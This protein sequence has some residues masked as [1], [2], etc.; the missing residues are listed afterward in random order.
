MKFKSKTMTFAQNSV[1]TTK[2]G[3]DLITNPLLNKG[4]A[5]T[6]EERDAYF[7]H[8]LL[9]CHFAT[10]AEQ[11]QRSYET[12]CRKDSDI[13]KYIYLRDLQDS[14][15]TLFYNLICT[16]MTEML[17]IVYTPVVGQGCQSFSETYRRPRG[18]YLAYPNQDRIEKILSAPHFQNTKIIVVSDGERILGLGDQGAG[19][20]GIP[21]GKLA[22]YSACAGVHPATT[23]PILLDTGTNNQER[24]NDPLYIGWKHERIRG[25][26]YDT[27][28]ETFVRAIKHQF[29]HVVLQW[30]DFAQQNAH[31]ILDKYREQLC[32]FNDDIQG[33]AAVATA[34]ILSALHLSGQ[35]LAEQ[36]IVVLGGGSAGCGINDLLIAAMMTEG[37]SEAEALSR[38]YVI[39]R[40][41]LL[42][43]GMKDLL[44]FQTKFCQAKEK[45]QDWPV[46]QKIELLDVIKQVH[47]TILIGV[48]GQ[49]GAFTETIVRT[50]AMHTERPIILPLSNPTICS[51]AQPSDLLTWTNGRAIIGTGSPFPPVLLNGISTR[52]DQTNNAYI[53]PGLGL[54]LIAVQAN[55]VTD[56]LFM[57]AAKALADC[58]PAIKDPQG[59]LLPPLERIREVSYYI[60]VAV[61]KEAVKTGLTQRIPEETIDSI[62]GQHMWEPVYASYT[63]EQDK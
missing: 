46:K 45:I 39:D 10:I 3:Y 48:S 55:K 56:H 26:E 44:P 58:S 21:I 36:R 16:Y 40:Q 37:V 62:V 1:E 17:P 2:S 32:T 6:P 60:A 18:L 47:P 4:M 19:G 27:F 57:T 15:E 24:I 34:T 29:P 25:K 9:P 51:E 11:R 54:G 30:E 49:A 13:E 7:L 35:T 59:N 53:F 41:G 33:T 20:M 31:P 50:M 52:I 43:T 14:N 22:L 63:V 42:I 23:L 12:F 8:G 28:I 61:A 38:F 5:F